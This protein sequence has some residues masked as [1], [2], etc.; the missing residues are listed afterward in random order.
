MK[1]VSRCRHSFLLLFFHLGGGPGSCLEP[2][3]QSFGG[4]VCARGRDAHREEATR[5]CVLA[6][7]D[8]LSHIV[9][10]VQAAA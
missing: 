4:N 1:H 10:H 7:F 5:M 9:A 6:G 2:F 8:G 3:G